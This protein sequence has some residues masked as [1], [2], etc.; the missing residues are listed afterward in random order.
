MTTT[1]Y[2]PPQAKNLYP[3]RTSYQTSDPAGQAM[4]II[5]TAFVLVVIVGLTYFAHSMGMF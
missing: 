1:R 2:T 3:R 5:N 4:R